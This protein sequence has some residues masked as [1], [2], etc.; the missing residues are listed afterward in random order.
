MLIDMA[1]PWDVR[2]L[3]AYFLLR[4]T[5][6]GVYGVRRAIVADAVSLI[7]MFVI[8]FKAGVWKRK[9]V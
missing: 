9:K 4:I 5:S 7:I 3:L 6:L 1:N 8:Y 2:M